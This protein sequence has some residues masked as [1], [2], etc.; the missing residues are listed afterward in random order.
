MAAHLYRKP[1]YSAV[2]SNQWAE[3]QY[4]PSFFF[5]FCFFKWIIYYCWSVHKE[6]L[7]WK[8]FSI[9]VTIFNFP[10]FKCI[11]GMKSLHIFPWWSFSTVMP[12]RFHMIVQTESFFGCFFS[13]WPA[14]TSSHLS[15]LLLANTLDSAAELAL[16][17]PD[18]RTLRGKKKKKN[19]FSVRC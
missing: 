5:F 2:T 17:N 9:I 11:K 19:T 18:C 14:L 6:K 10:T 7:S 16:H 4:W 1:E 13:A 12:T 8:L 15:L 3:I